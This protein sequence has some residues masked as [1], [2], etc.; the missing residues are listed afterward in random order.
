MW[1]NERWCFRM[2]FFWATYLIN[3]H[4]VPIVISYRKDKEQKHWGSRRA[5]ARFERYYNSSVKMKKAFTEDQNDLNLPG[6]L[7]HIQENPENVHVRQVLGNRSGDE[8]PAKLP[9]KLS[10]CRLRDLGPYMGEEIMRQY[11]LRG[12]K[13]K[14]KGYGKEEFKPEEWDESVWPWATVREAF[15][16]DTTF[17]IFWGS[18]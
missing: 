3:K 15:T 17:L 9:S 18:H 1:T 4:N 11:R 16:N 13:L 14:K 6:T 12:G 2:L 5:K 10:L 7:G 8:V